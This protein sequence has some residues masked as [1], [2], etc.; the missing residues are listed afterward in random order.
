LGHMSQQS[1]SPHFLQIL[2]F[3]YHCAASISLPSPSPLCINRIIT[4]SSLLRFCIR[5]SST[6]FL[7]LRVS[8]IF[9]TYRSIVKYNTATKKNTYCRLRAVL[10]YSSHAC[11]YF[12]FI[13]HILAAIIDRSYFVFC[14]FCYHRLLFLGCHPQ[15]HTYTRFRPHISSR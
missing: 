14:E 6:Y 4:F 12:S 11:L 13:P 2:Q 1:K 9:L 15:Q 5:T 7:I 10:P 8:L 3:S